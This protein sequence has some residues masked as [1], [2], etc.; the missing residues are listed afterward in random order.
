ML[1]LQV[2]MYIQVL[3][4]RCTVFV[5]HQKILVYLTQVPAATVLF[6]ATAGS[7]VYYWSTS[8]HCTVLYCS[9]SCY[10]MRILH[11]LA[12]TAL[13]MGTAGTDICF[14][15]TSRHCTVFIW[16]QWILVQVTEVQMSDTS[17]QCQG[18]TDKYMLFSTIPV[19]VAVH[20]WSTVQCIL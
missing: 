17:V 8:R 15:S 18:I 2:L 16:L 13:R 9:S 12:A 10:C 14:W 11:V 7:N 20:Y 4:I 5:W 6:V 19:S 3:P 1:L